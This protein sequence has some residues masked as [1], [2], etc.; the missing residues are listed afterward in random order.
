LLALLLGTIG[1]YSVMAFLA[2]QRRR[3]IGI[4]I[5]LGALPARVIGRFAGQGMRWISVG[6]G[7][8]A[9]ASVG[10]LRVL[11]SLVVGVSATDLVSVGTVLIVLAATGF[12]ACYVP[13]SSV[14]RRSPTEVLR[15]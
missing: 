9:F 8:G 13:T 14:C 11:Q 12:A 6:L 4:R 3:E 5:A 1:T 15:E 10:A 2:F 7:I